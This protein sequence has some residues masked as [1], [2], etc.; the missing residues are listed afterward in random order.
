MLEHAAY[1]DERTVFVIVEVVTMLYSGILGMS[2]HMLFQT[3]FQIKLFIAHFTI[4]FLHQFKFF[5]VVF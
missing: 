3:P 2:L 4:V 5:H 1:T